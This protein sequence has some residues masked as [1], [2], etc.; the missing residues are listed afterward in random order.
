MIYIAIL[1]VAM[2][3][4]A[5][6][7][8]HLGALLLVV[9]FAFS[10]FRFEVGCDWSG[11]YNQYRLAETDP[12]GL[13]GL[14][15]LWRGLLLLTDL[16]DLEYPWLNVLSSAIFFAGVFA[17]ARRQPDP[18]AFLI[19]LFPFL[20]INMPMSAI[21]QAAAIGAL[22]FAYNAFIDRKLMRFLLMLGIASLFHTSAL[23]ILL[24]APF[25]GGFGRARI[26]LTLALA[27]PLAAIFAN[28]QIADV[29]E[30]RYLESGKEAAGALFRVAMLSA[31]GLAFF[32]LLSK[33]W[34][35]KSVSD[36]PLMAA[37]AV[38]ML[39]L[40]VLLLLSS[41]IADRL[42]YFLTPIQAI[43]LARIPYL[44]VGVS[45]NVVI[46][47]PYVVFLALFIAYIQYSTLFDTCYEPYRT[48][49][50]GT[51]ESR[52]PSLYDSI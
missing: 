49:L 30:T 25:V 13:R 33:S 6:R 14:E 37:G 41:V 46:I 18:A 21:R 32:S 1:A 12:F 24:L 23:A 2:V 50:F 34:R 40:P 38:G 28:S 42:G 45:R 19:F 31:T 11:Y 29:V 3:L 51:P 36:Y 5:F 8:P 35:E 52:Y 47:A 43:I 26:A 16:L 15:P 10:A 27:I 22:C 39:F 20:I 17:M 9:F 4:R 44:Q 48:W 7:V